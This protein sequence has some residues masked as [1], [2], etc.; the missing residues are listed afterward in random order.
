MLDELFLVIKQ[1]FY[2]AKE[3]IFKFKSNCDKLIFVLS[4]EIGIFLSIE[5]QNVFV[6]SLY[7]GDSIG[8][9]SILAN[10]N[11][12]MTGITQK[13]CLVAIL[14]KVDLFKLVLKYP[15]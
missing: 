14:S 7:R 12:I 3:V 5:G 13:P 9:N 2:Q 6:E 8:S 11:F 4:G 15:K 1:D 10:K